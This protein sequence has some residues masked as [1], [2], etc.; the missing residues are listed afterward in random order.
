MISSGKCRLRN[1]SAGT[2]FTL[3]YTVSNA[4]SATLQT[5]QYFAYDSSNNVVDTGALTGSP[6]AQNATLTAPSTTGTYT[7]ALTC[8]GQESGFATL[9]VQ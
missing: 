9:N 5:C 1:H 2:S 7:Y 6:T 4:Y 3:G 8:G